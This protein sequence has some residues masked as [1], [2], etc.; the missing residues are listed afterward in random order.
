[1]L[2]EDDYTYLYP[3]MSPAEISEE[4]GKYSKG[5]RYIQKLYKGKGYL[6]QRIALNGIVAKSYAIADLEVD[7]RVDSIRVERNSKGTQLP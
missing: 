1:M 7:E 3:L 6:P 5:A 4:Y 2:A